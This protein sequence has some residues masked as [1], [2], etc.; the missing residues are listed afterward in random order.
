MGLKFSIILPTFNRLGAILHA[1]NSALAQSFRDFELIIVDDGSTDS[2]ENVIRDKFSEQIAST[3]IRFFRIETNR[4][5][6]FA[7]NLGIREARGEWIAYLDSDNELKKDALLLFDQLIQKKQEKKIFYS[8][9]IRKVRRS[10]IGGTWSPEKLRLKNFIDLGTFVHSREL[11]FELG[12]FDE[13]LCRLVDWDL[14]LNYTSHYEPVFLNEVTLIYN[15][16]KDPSRISNSNPSEPNLEII[17]TKY[18][19]PT[20][21]I[22]PLHKILRRI[23]IRDN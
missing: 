11:F 5:V 3:L 17:R 15:D 1:I 6:C 16:E 18:P 21:S 22:S 12:G 4:G 7:R 14:I 19:L 23:F 10:T 9:A 20:T 8:K 2:T 13:R